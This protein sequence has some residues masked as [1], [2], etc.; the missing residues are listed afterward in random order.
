MRRVGVIIGSDSDLDQCFLGL[1]F[2]KEAEKAGAIKADPVI[3]A[4]IHRN[5]LDVLDLLGKYNVDVWII[6]AGAAN[7]LTGVCEAFLRYA[8]KN[9][10]TAVIGVAFE[11]SDKEKSLAAKLGI[12]QVPDT[13]TV[14]NNFIGENGFFFA[15]EF[16]VFGKFPRITLK[17]PK[18][19]IRRTLDAALDEAKTRRSQK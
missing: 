18:P 2:L 9:D 1:N 17:N 10:K 3:T 16:A 14:F 11:S 15:C 4:S 19:I 12:T 7:H 8:I 6:G 13:Q 5:T